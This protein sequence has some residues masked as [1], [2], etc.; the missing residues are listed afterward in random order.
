MLR[1]GALEGI[2]EVFGLH[3]LP[4]VP[5]GEVRVKTG[6]VMGRSTEL[7]IEVRGR[8]GHASQPHNGVDPVVAGAHVV[9]ALQTVVS[10][11][12]PAAHQAV[13]SLTNFA[14]GSGALNVIPDV[15]RLSG[16]IRDFHDDAFATI[17][18]AVPRV[19]HGVCA[20]LGATATVDI[21][22]KYPPVVN[23]PAA[24]A[25]VARAAKRVLKKRE[26]DM[27]L[28]DGLPLLAGEDFSY[29]LRPKDGGL[30]HGAFFFV[31]TAEASYSHYADFSKPG[32]FADAV[33]RSNCTIHST[34]YDF[35][36]NALPIAASLFVRLVEDR[37]GADLFPDDAL[38]YDRAS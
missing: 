37:L 1:A 10:R 34:A 17:A 4:T 22:T 6:A 36:D 16:T 20:G 33:C 29:F 38:Y 8:G 30:R 23:D 31:G 12:V 9:A 25:A 7:R 13:L 24:V 26:C 18:R 11:E 19:V 15:A 2:D 5:L 3:N 14:A 21:D 32:A 27:R 28:D 35:N